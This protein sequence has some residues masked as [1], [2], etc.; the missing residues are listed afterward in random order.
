MIEQEAG[1]LPETGLQAFLLGDSSSIDI[2]RDYHR[3][4]AVILARTLETGTWRRIGLVWW[5]ALHCVFKPDYHKFVSFEAEVHREFY[6]LLLN[7][8]RSSFRACQSSSSQ[9][10][11]SICGLSCSSPSHFLNTKVSVL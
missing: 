10:G 1:L 6:L 9:S 5:E 4:Y 3:T 2:P 8:S 7:W 11:F